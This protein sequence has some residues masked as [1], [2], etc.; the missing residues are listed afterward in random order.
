MKQTID[1]ISTLIFTDISGFVKHTITRHIDGAEMVLIPAGDFQMGSDEG[2]DENPVHTVYLDAYYIDKYEVTNS[3]YQKFLRAN[4]EWQKDRIPAQYHDGYYL[5]NWDGIN[6]P[7]DKADHPVVCVSWFAAAAYA[8]WVG[9]HLPT[10]AQWEKASRGGVSGK[11]YPWGDELS[12][13]YANYEGTGG[14][15]IWDE[16]SP[17][18][19]F[20]H[21]GYGLYD[22][23]GNV[24]EWCADRYDNSYYSYSPQR[25]P[26]GPSDDAQNQKCTRVLRGGSWI[27]FDLNFLRCA[28]RASAEPIFT[29]TDVGF[30]CAISCN[31]QDFINHQF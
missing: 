30:R 14:K 20:P 6:Y 4:P 9:A 24:W 21:N 17:V 15:D 27:N 22:M 28:F 10:E 5:E 18:G 23:I 25:N 19:S 16:T 29:L 12:H 2:Y 13:D 7:A 3:Q 11:K 8:K 1:L 26:V 31:K